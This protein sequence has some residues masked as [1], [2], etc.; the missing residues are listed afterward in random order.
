VNRGGE[1]SPVRKSG[2]SLGTELLV[3]NPT[4]QQLSSLLTHHDSHL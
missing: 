1:I 2:R 4:G 3:N